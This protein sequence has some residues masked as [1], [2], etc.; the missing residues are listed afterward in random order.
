[1]KIAIL[2]TGELR[3]FAHTRPLYTFLDQTD[4]DIDVYVNTWLINPLSN[5]IRKGVINTEPVEVMTV[6]PEYIHGILGRPATVQILDPAQVTMIDPHPV[7]SWVTGLEL[8]EK[9]GIHYDFIW[10]MRPDLC[11]SQDPRLIPEQIPKFAGSNL[12]GIT[13]AREAHQRHSEKFFP[14][15]SIFGSRETIKKIISSEL[16]ELC[17]QENVPRAVWHRIL[18]THIQNCGLVAAKD[19]ILP[20]GAVPARWPIQDPLTWDQAKTTWF[21]WMNNNSAVN[22]CFVGWFQDFALHRENCLLL[23]QAGINAYNFMVLLPR[24][25]NNMHIPVPDKEVYDTYMQPGNVRPLWRVNYTNEKLLAGRPENE[26]ERTFFLWQAGLM[27]MGVDTTIAG[28]KTARGLGCVITLIKSHVFR[29]NQVSYDVEVIRQNKIYTLDFDKIWVSK[30][31]QG[32]YN[33]DYICGSVSRIIPLINN[34][35]LERWLQAKAAGQNWRDW[36]H[37]EVSTWGVDQ[38][39]C[40]VIMTP[41]K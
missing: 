38:S 15:F 16:I 31:N 29:K 21:E 23:D 6:T 41:N 34:D 17:K 33:L 14:D 35:L 24:F 40:P 7:T 9:S 19:P 22:T 30:N 25:Q 28:T 37:D 3:S 2:F 1:M 26:W 5:T 12:V 13:Q 11:F 36:W 8:V 20:H 4:L 32:R 10:V 39:P 18:W 27:R